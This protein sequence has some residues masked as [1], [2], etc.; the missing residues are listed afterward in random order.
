MVRRTSLGLCLSAAAHAVVG[1]GLWWAAPAPRRAA[2]AADLGGAPSPSL[3]P[4]PAPVPIADEV[5]ELT[6]VELP[7]DELLETS[8][9]PPPLTASVAAAQRDA[10]PRQA[11]PGDEQIAT[12]AA[13]E[14]AAGTTLEP[15][16]PGAKPDDSARSR[17]GMRDPLPARLIMPDL[18]KIAEARDSRLAVAVAIP[19]ELAKAGGGRYQSNQGS[20]TAK[21][22][23]DG[24]VE[25][26]DAPNLS[27]GFSV[28]DPK[29]LGRGL[30]DW[31]AD[32]YAQTR[33][34][35][36]EIE[37]GEVPSG[38]VDDA[39]EQRKRPKT[40][41][42]ITGS[43]D[44]TDWL[45]RLSGR[46]PYWAAKMSFLNRTREARVQMAQGHRS[47]MLRGAAK[48]I[49]EQ[50]RL[51]WA[52]PGQSA[53]ARRRALF[54]LWEECAETGDAE[55]VEAA[56]SARR[57]VYGFIRGHLPAGSA[58]AYSDDELAS[59]NRGSQSRQRF[60]PYED[61]PAAAQE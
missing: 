24:T 37:G 18:K 2:S 49:R 33:D 4:A 32:P 45:M 48:M 19:E 34:R 17:L 26:K 51:A 56:R 46:D 12:R 14:A 22:N 5:L 21:V 58:D 53:G 40:V 13:T 15:A 43:F 50:A 36:R 20:F 59:L 9:P 35:E 57:A 39:E 41:P 16:P 8:P 1:A 3:V 25:L 38:A 55:L 27:V 52:A 23:R 29:A 7:P 10:R 6:I 31:Y 30:A 54:E 47:E 42:I 11:S 61:A 44:V 60:A 28:P